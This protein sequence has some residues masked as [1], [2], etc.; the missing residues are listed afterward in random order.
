[1][2]KRS[3][4]LTAVAV[5][6]AL[7]GGQKAGAALIPF[8]Y[9]TTVVQTPVSGVPNP[10]FTVDFT[11]VGPVSTSADTAN[12]TDVKLGTVSY[13]D[14]SGSA[15]GSVPFS[16]NYTY[17]LNITG[18]SNT[19]DVTGNL[20]GTITGGTSG[21]SANTNPSFPSSIAPP[22]VT[23]GG[24]QFVVIATAGK[25]FNA[26]GSP[27][28]LGTGEA[29]GFTIQLKAVP[30]PASMVLMGIGGLGTLGLFLRRRKTV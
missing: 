24:Q 26:P 12:P 10:F 14:T 27:P 13:T 8:T 3:L 11:G 18:A 7:V 16:T 6:L 28:S 30:E 15:F 2:F 21:D 20:S 9:S 1:M 5:A 22:T 19:V 25:Y 29:G 23:I 4:S 17:T